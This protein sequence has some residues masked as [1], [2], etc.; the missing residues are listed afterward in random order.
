[1]VSF[2]EFQLNYF[3]RQAA[4]LVG[5]SSPQDAQILQ[6]A[7][8]LPDGGNSVLWGLLDTVPE[9][10]PVFARSGGSFFAAYAR[11]IESLVPANPS[12]PLDVVSLAQR[13]L[14]EW[15][16]RPPAWNTTA[17]KILKNLQ[18]APSHSFSFSSPAEIDHG[19]WGLWTEAS[20]DAGL[21]GRFAAGG[22]S[23]A[24]TF[25][26]QHL[27]LVNPQPDDWYTSSAITLAYATKKGS[28][29]NPQSDVTW[30]SAFG[31]NGT[32][33][34]VVASLVCVGGLNLRYQAQGPFGAADRATL[35]EQRDAGLWPSYLP[36][37]VAK[38]KVAFTKDGKLDVTI[39][40][41]ANRPIVINAVVLPASRYFGGQ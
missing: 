34:R 33:Q 31:K 4:N 7:V 22:V 26:Y 36:A 3:H 39:G 15:G 19:F 40:T 5:S 24:P 12:N 9:T 27:L 13:N 20:P 10:G 21:E 6:G 2:N 16:D 14:R 8:P 30:E 23:S 25:D 35:Q 28:P 38:T 1:M 11:I 32:L 41:P 18:R 37:P 17:D 29:W